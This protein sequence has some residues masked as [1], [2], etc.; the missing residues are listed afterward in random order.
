MTGDSYVDGN[1]VG[2]LLVELFGREMTDQHG[3][4]DH[5]GA[6]NVLAAVHV[7]LDAPGTIIRCP[8]CESVLIVIVRNPKSVRISFGEIRWLEDGN[9]T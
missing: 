1:A 7:Y 3:C 4:C 6:V 8:N 5:C 2:G 9:V